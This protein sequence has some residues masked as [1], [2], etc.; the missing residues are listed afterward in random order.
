MF[1]PRATNSPQQEMDYQSSVDGERAL[2]VVVMEDNGEGAS[3][4][5]AETMQKP[6]PLAGRDSTI[7]IQQEIH[8]VEKTLLHFLFCC[9]PTRCLSYRYCVS[10]PLFYIM[11]CGAG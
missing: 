2:S 8:A 4:L 1:N 9:F 11:C 7:S 5:R 3:P 10:L 6:I